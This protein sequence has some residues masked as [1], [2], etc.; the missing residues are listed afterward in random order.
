MSNGLYAVK[1]SD[2]NSK[3]YDDLKITSSSLQFQQSRSNVSINSKPD[4]FPGKTPRE[5]FER[6]NPPP[7][8]N[9]ESAKLQPPGKKK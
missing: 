5:L 6:A 4:N 7:P 3:R 9:Q 2:E 1:K 8:G